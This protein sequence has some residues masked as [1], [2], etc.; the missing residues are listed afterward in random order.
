MARWRS[1]QRSSLI[2]RRPRVRLPP[3]RPFFRSVAEEQTQRA[4][5]AP[6]SRASQ[7][8]VLPLRP[9]CRWRAG[10]LTGREGGAWRNRRCMVGRETHPYNVFN[11]D[12]SFVRTWR[13]SRRN[14]PRCRRAQARVGA[15]P[16][17]RTNFDGW[18][19]SRH[20]SL[21]N[22]WAR[23]RAGATPVPSTTSLSPCPLTSQETRLSIGQRGC[24]SRRGDHFSRQ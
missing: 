12:S 4:V 6:P 22:S 5:N 23:A 20:P 3:E 21:R 14:G 1:S 19:N 9:R 17:V 13:N 18:W 10:L 11:Q 8:Q 15:N 16:S 7:V 2:R 24:D